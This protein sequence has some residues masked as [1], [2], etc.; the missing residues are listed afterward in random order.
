LQWVPKASFTSLIRPP[1]STTRMPSLD[2]LDAGPVEPP[3]EAAVGHKHVVPHG[4]EAAPE[5]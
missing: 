2:V 3:V 5:T 4:A 1:L